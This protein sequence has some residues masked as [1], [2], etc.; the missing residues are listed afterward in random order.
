MVTVSLHINWGLVV[1]FFCFFL[2][3]M[4]ALIFRS[5]T[6]S[7]PISRAILLTFTYL[8]P[9]TSAKYCIHLTISAS[10]KGFNSSFQLPVFL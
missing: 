5:P 8:K 7:L 3:D 4:E 1:F 9:F 6:E 2:L 10:M